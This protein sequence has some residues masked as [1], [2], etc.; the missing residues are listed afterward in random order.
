MPASC[1]RVILATTMRIRW[2]LMGLLGA[3]FALGLCGREGYRVY[4]I[5]TP[6]PAAKASGPIQPIITVSV[7]DMPILVSAAP[8][9]GAV[10]ATSLRAST[11]LT[12]LLLLGP[13]ETVDESVWFMI[14]CL[15]SSTRPKPIYRLVGLV[16]GQKKTAVRN[17]F[18]QRHGPLLVASI[19]WRKVFRFLAIELESPVARA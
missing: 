5:V 13:I 8:V 19:C 12:K 7:I 11:A 6:A 2:G 4:R 9:I 18:R 16:T 15:S 1:L 10:S 17:Q 3:V 14:A